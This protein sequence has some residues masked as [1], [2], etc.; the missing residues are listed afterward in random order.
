VPWGA[1]A[2]AAS[3]RQQQCQEPQ[4]VASWHPTGRGSGSKGSIISSRSAMGSGEQE[5]QEQHEQ[6]QE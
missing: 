1:E 3:K 2:G 4:V 5:W 6:K